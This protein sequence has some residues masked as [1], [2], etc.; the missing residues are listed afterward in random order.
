MTKTILITGATDGI[1]LATA[2]N[3]VAKG[4]T[5]LIHGRNTDKLAAVKAQLLAL[6]TEDVNESNVQTYVAD[7][8]ILSEVKALANSIKAEHTSLDV[9]INNAGVYKTSNP[10]TPEG[11]DV[12]FSVNTIAPFILTQQLAPLLEKSGRVVN[13]SSAAQA[14]V[15]IDA[16][17]GKTQLA[18]MEA[19][20]QSKL[21]LTMLSR[22]MANQYKETGP[23]VFSVNPGSLLASKMVKKGFG[24]EGK[25]LSIGANILVKSALSD[26]FS[27]ATGLYFDNDIGQFSAP[28]QDALDVQKTAKLTEAIK[29]I[30]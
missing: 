7:L 3:L 5:L 12:R 15:N 27:E 13:L 14:P 10:I 19:Y 30:V 16:L 18:A 9:L 23:V 21:A 22:D 20:A 26:E 25:D 29:S 24:I 6:T 17:L 8:S 4:H 1:G 11:L 2:K 28:H